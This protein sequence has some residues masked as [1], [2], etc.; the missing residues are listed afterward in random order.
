MS[1]DEWGNLLPM[2]IK[3]INTLHRAGARFCTDTRNINKG[4]I[5]IALEGESFDGNAFVEAALESGAAAVIGKIGKS[6]LQSD[7]ILFVEDPLKTLQD[8]A[9]E[10]RET[11]NIPVIG[12]TGSNGKTTT[13]ELIYAVLSQKYKVSATRGNLNNHIGVPLTLLGIQND[14][15]IAI[16]EMGANHIG[17]IRQLCKIALPDHGIITNI[18]KAH[19]E[20]FGGYAGVIRA[21]SELYNHLREDLGKVFV[22]SGD[23]LL[24]RLSEGINRITYG[25]SS[26]LNAEVDNKDFFIKLEWSSGPGYGT[27]TETNL[28]GSYNLT[29][30]LA[31]AS[32]GIY[33]DVPWTVIVQAISNYTP[34]NNRSEIRK[35]S[36]NTLLLDAYNAN[37]SSMELSLENFDGL[38]GDKK[39]AILGDML[40]LGDEAEQEHRQILDKAKKMDFE[41]L[42]L[43]GPVFLSISEGEIP[44]FDKVEACHDWLR[45]NQPE[46]RFILLKGS[47][48]IR[49]EHLLDLL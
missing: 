9:L 26:K 4:D 38:K 33:F 1:T 18:G 39:W 12:I 42:I 21:K 29:N 27:R 48:G 15:E 31:A 7:R 44:A 23:A 13:K 8:L 30:I 20:G 36:R 10:Y 11:L 41:K 22:N 40:E 3:Q 16:I 2:N 14:A 28:S 47:R 46:N 25:S 24:M 45:D 34:K 32:I 35:T 17:E 6:T 19:L 5:F 43:V 49:L 37:P